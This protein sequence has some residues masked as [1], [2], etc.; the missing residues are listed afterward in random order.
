MSDFD[1]L[2]SEVNDG[3]AGRNGGLPMGFQRLNNH[4][5]LRKANNYLVGGFT[6]TGKTG[7][8][9]DAF[10]LNP[11]SYHI[12]HPDSTSIEI[13]YWSMERPRKFKLMKWISRK[14]FL[15]HGLIIPVKRWMGWCNEADRIKPEEKLIFET[16]REYI[17]A[18]LS[19]IHI[20]DSSTDHNPTGF[21]NIMREFFAARGTI[22]E[23]VPAENGNP[24]IPRLY[25]PHDPRKIIL[26]IK[27]HLG[28]IRNEKNLNIKKDI[29]DKVAQDD[30]YF[31]DFYGASNVHISQF[32]RDISNP[33]RLK[34]GDVEPMLE[35]FKD[36]GSTQEDADVVISL[37][38]PSRYKVP[39]PSRYDLDKLTHQGDLKY[40]SIK[41][42]KN[43]YGV[44]NI[45]IGM[46]FQGSTG[47]FKELP[48]LDQIDDNIYSSV[49]DDSY[50]LPHH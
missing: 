45:R 21:R 49:R 5:T 50:F 41:I 16:Y 22:R 6:G 32:N 26:I 44:A 2:L 48:H 34:N 42:L 12:V 20:F 3:I 23:R 11:I 46:G 17:N 40:R 35:D 18:I 38:D 8:V 31:R 30:R 27:D 36:S 29:I 25:I 47:M 14:I 13:V 4:V 39:D 24:P 28:L 9:D 7:F 19:K 37:F 15:D 33:T 1:D 43:S 10:V